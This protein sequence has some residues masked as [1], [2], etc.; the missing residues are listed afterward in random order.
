MVTKTPASFLNRGSLVRIRPVAFLPYAAL[1]GAVSRF[2]VPTKEL[3]ASL[4]MAVALAT[5]RDAV[6]SHSVSRWQALGTG[7]GDWAYWPGLAREIV[8]EPPANA[9]GSGIFKAAMHRSDQ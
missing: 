6:P 7:F 1:G 9:C 5:M 3:R 4:G 2:S 8:V